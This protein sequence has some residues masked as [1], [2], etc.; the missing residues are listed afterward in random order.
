VQKNYTWISGKQ[1]ITLSASLITEI[2]IVKMLTHKC[3]N[4]LTHYNTSLIAI[5]V[6]LNAGIILRRC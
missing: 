3:C 2:N 1:R 4:T 5:F 6:L